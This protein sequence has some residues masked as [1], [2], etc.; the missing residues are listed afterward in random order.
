MPLAEGLR[1]EL[2]ELLEGGNA[3]QDFDS[4][5]SDFPAKLRGQRPKGLAYSAWELLEHMRI[6]QN[7]ILEFIRDPNYTSP[8][9]PEGYWPATPAPL[10]AADWDRSIEAFRAD[11]QAILELIAKPSHDLIKPIPHGSGQNL[12]REALLVADHT[13]YHLGQLIAVRRLLGC[14]PPKK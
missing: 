14:W 5:V 7:D 4:A 3:H 11:R 9:W 6:A 10:E 2:R 8:P 12:L 1:K 13:A